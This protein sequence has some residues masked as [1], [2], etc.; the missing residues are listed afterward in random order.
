MYPLFAAIVFSLFLSRPLSRPYRD[1]V[2]TLPSPCH[3]FMM[4]HSITTMAA[5][6]W[7][8]EW[9][10]LANDS[11]APANSQKAIRLA[12][13][14]QTYGVW[15]ADIPQQ[16]IENL[17]A[18]RSPDEILQNRRARTSGRSHTGSQG[19]PVVNASTSRERRLRGGLP[20]LRG[21]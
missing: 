20:L 4:S 10:S 19:C 2:F 9:K 13:F 17:V 14:N 12:T 6:P 8:K 5:S 21:H 18:G 11:M 16:A 3:K 1:L 7:A 15:P